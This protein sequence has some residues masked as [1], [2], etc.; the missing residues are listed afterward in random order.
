MFYVVAKITTIEVKVNTM[1]HFLMRRG[2]AEAVHKGWATMNSPIV[3]NQDAKEL[4]APMAEE[5]RAFYEK[6]QKVTDFELALAI[7]K[8]FGERLAK[9][10]CIPNGF[11]L[12]ACLVIAVSVAKD[13]FVGGG[14]LV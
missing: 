13:G 6:N 10:I 1:W 4:L 8:Q 14:V 2:E 11:S 9:E 7:E 5:L 3:V 12:G